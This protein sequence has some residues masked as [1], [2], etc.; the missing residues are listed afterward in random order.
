MKRSPFSAIIQQLFADWAVNRGVLKSQ[1]LMLLFRALSILPR[2]KFCSLISFPFLLLYKFYSGMLLNVDLS[3]KTTVGAGLHLPHPYGI[4]VHHKAVI[5]SC[6]TVRHGVTI[7]VKS[8]VGRVECPV[9]GNRVDFGCGVVVIGP[10]SVG[11]GAILG[12]NVVI[13]KNVSCSA[14]IIGQPFRLKS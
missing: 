14:T 5:G 12:A 8:V 6:C 3:P 2:N 13:T 10:V 11:D 4:V 7:G 9:I 1:I